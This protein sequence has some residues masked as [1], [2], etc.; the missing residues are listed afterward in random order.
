MGLGVAV[1][2]ATA[3]WGIEVK[4]YVYDDVSYL[5]LSEKDGSLKC[6]SELAPQ[7]NLGRCGIPAAPRGAQLLTLARFRRLDPGAGR[8]QP[9]LHGLGNRPKP[10]G[11]HR[12]DRGFAGD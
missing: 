2:A 7:I 3:V 5:K 12:T 4:N 10:R 8:E 6:G 1:L 11:L 9:E